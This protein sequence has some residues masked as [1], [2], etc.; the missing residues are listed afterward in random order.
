M[1]KSK[2]AG[3][4][5]IGVSML[6]LMLEKALLEDANGDY[7][8]L[9]MVVFFVYGFLANSCGSCCIHFPL[10]LVAIKAIVVIVVLKGQAYECKCNLPLGVTFSLFHFLSSSHGCLSSQVW[11]LLNFK[12]I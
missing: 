4:A 2:A 12:L 8:C 10:H 11:H 7:G 6:D 1:I 3:V 5:G 9:M